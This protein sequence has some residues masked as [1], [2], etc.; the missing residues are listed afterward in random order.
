MVW[1]RDDEIVNVLMMVM[2]M[3]TVSCGGE[4]QL[5][6]DRVYIFKMILSSAVFIE[7]RY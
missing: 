5:A 4:P 1:K 6:D 3:M 7:A 2:I